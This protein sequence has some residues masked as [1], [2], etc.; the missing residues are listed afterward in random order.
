MLSSKQLIYNLVDRITTRFTKLS[1][2]T[3]QNDQNVN[4]TIYN[5]TG[6]KYRNIDISTCNYVIWTASNGTKSK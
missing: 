3:G 4:S 5:K 2:V 1:Y 6:R